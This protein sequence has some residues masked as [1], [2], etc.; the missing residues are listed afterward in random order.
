MD[1]GQHESVTIHA[2][3]INLARCVP[4]ICPVTVKCTL[5]VFF[6][7]AKL[8]RVVEPPPLPWQVNPAY[9]PCLGA[10]H[11]LTH[12][13]DAAS[14]HSLLAT[15]VP[16]GA[17]PASCGQR[18][19]VCPAAQPVFLQKL[20]WLHRSPTMPASLRITS[21]R[22]ARCCSAITTCSPGEV[23]AQWSQTATQPAAVTCSGAAL[24]CCSGCVPDIPE[25]GA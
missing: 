24:D 6:G 25:C 15:T 21:M 19:E 12:S 23:A 20:P 13:G 2:P 1:V 7:G 11:T 17:R 5:Q 4:C 22:C 16:S 14:S 9:G 3:D 18:C 8:V 10:L